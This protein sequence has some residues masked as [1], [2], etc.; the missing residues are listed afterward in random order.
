VLLEAD[1][2]LMQE[3]EPGWPVLLE[4]TWRFLGVEQHSNGTR[5][6]HVNGHHGPRPALSARELE[7]LALLAEHQ[8]NAQI[9]EALTVS[10]AT[11]SKHVHNILGKLGMN[12]RSEAAAWWATNSSDGEE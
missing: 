10:H 5:N 7:V 2:H 4:E 3:Y 12:R 9:A 1:N 11:A 6:G 8:T